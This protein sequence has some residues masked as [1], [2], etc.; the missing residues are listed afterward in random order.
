MPALRARTG[1]CP[2]RADPHGGEPH[3]SYTA[4]L[5]WPG[6][7]SASRSPGDGGAKN[8][9]AGTQAP[10]PSDPAGTFATVP[11][12]CTKTPAEPPETVPRG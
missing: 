12:P 4:R 10:L 5:A 11:K 8:P 2:Q 7:P 1:L 9:S 6:Q 3:G